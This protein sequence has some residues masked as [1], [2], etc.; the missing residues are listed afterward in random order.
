MSFEYYHKLEVE[1]RGGKF[2][3]LTDKVTGGVIY[4]DNALLTDQ[5]VFTLGKSALSYGDLVAKGAKI[6]YT[7]G[8]QAPYQSQLLFMGI[9]AIKKPLFPNNGVPQ[10]KIQALDYSYLLSQR[11]PGN[12]AYPSEWCPARSTAEDVTMRVSD[13]ITAI[14]KEY[15]E[16]EYSSDTIQIP[17][18]LDREFNLKAP[19]VQKENESDWAFIQRL[20]QGDKAKNKKGLDR[21][22][23]TTADDG[24]GCIAFVE[25]MNDKPAFFVVPEKVAKEEKGT[26]KFAYQMEGLNII[27]KFDPTREDAELYITDIDVTDSPATADVEPQKEIKINPETG[28]ISEVTRNETGDIAQVKIYKVNE[29]MVAQEY[30]SNSQFL[31]EITVGEADS[32]DKVKR[33]LVPIETK[34]PA[35][36]RQ[37]T[38]GV[39]S[40]GKTEK[41][42]ERIG[43]LGQELDCN[44]RGCIHIYGKRS[45]EVLNL[46][47]TYSGWWFLEQVTHRFEKVY[48]CNLKFKR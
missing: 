1:G 28:E 41:E 11:K 6:K 4:E 44:S 32:F 34:Y 15:P 13:I 24:I 12:I 47:D 22:T 17:A 48:A 20:C 26:V 18:D 43:F 37:E 9:V 25:L 8:Y 16:I 19:M 42:L 3:D 33:F 38:P 5:L 14:L 30:E 46:G 31:Q 23:K 2:I 29:A 35:S 36:M 27:Q 40:S 7:A 21:I 45:Y 39:K 10:L